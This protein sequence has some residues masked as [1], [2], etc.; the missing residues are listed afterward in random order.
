MCHEISGLEI[1]LIVMGS[2]LLFKLLPSSCFQALQYV[3]CHARDE[4]CSICH[5]RALSGCLGAPLYS[6][7]SAGSLR[8]TGPWVR[9]EF[10]KGRADILPSL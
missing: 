10:S 2:K 9:P 6:G 7:P 4:L 8:Q 1:I 3:T 5:S